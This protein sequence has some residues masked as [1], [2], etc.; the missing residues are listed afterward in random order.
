METKGVG[1]RAESWSP[2]PTGAWEGDQPT[3]QSTPTGAE[4]R[5]ASREGGVSTCSVHAATECGRS[6]ISGF[7]TRASGHLEKSCSK[8]TKVVGSRETER[9]GDGECGRLRVSLRRAAETLRG[10]WRKVQIRSIL[11]F[12]FTVGATIA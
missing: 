9:T 10:G 8:G 5:E 3:R 7:C 12:S 1:S 6:S 2:L 4:V 11:G